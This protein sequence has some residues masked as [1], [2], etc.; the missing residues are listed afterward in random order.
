MD[1]E[2]DYYDDVPKGD[3]STGKIEKLRQFLFHDIGDEWLNLNEEFV[4][5]TANTKNFDKLA[6][7]KEVP[8]VRG[9]MEVRHILEMVRG[10][11]VIAGGYARYCCSTVYAPEMPGDV[12]IFF[13]NTKS[14]SEFRKM[15]EMKL[16]KASVVSDSVNAITYKMQNDGP[17]SLCPKVQLIKPKEDLEGG[18]GIYTFICKVMDDFDFTVCQAAIVSATTCVVGAAFKN[19]DDGKRLVFS[20]TKRNFNPVKELFR[21]MHYIQKGYYFNLD[22]AN[23]FIKGSMR[24]V[25]EKYGSILKEALP[26]GVT[27]SGSINLSDL[28]AVLNAVFNDN[29]ALR[30]AE[31]VR[32]QFEAERYKKSYSGRY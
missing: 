11:G 12:D 18:V 5:P 9:I 3:A 20:Q 22:D 27:P 1:Y 2:M 30:E 31:E 23:K 7:Y 16:A 21:V 29:L 14:L 10:L 26:N 17:F 13:P 6:L 4:S 24:L 25:F 19:D 28:D 32:G 8:T 15:L